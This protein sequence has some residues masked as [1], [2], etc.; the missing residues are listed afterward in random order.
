MTG[1]EGSGTS[2]TLMTC[3]GKLFLVSY[4]VYIPSRTHSFVSLSAALQASEVPLDLEFLD[5]ISRAALPEAL[6]SHARQ[7]C[8][9]FLY[10]YMVFSK[11]F[12]SSTRC[13]P[14]F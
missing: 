13:A 2:G 1:R 11:E 6:G 10:L 5:E 12:E 7:A 9:A 4:V 14:S 8:L 3:R